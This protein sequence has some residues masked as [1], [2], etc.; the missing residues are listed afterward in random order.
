MI[1][2]QAALVAIA[3][4]RAHER[5][6]LQEIAVNTLLA[7]DIWIPATAIYQQ[8]QAIARKR[9]RPFRERLSPFTHLLPPADYLN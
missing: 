8:A 7:R 5:F 9:G 2:E 3:T 6:D 4:F 1:D